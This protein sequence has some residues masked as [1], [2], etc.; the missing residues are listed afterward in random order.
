MVKAGEFVS[1]LL[2][3]CHCQLNCETAVLGAAGGIGQ[4]CFIFRRVFDLYTNNK[5]D[6]SSRVSRFLCS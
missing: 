1:S 2:T 4:V 5:T 6:L 3:V